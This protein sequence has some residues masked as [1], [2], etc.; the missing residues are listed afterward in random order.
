MK[1]NG[2]R[3]KVSNNVVIFTNN[4]VIFTNN[5]VIFTNND[6]IL[7]LPRSIRAERTALW[8]V[9]PVSL[10]IIRQRQVDASLFTSLTYVSFFSTRRTRRTQ[11]LT[12][13]IGV[14]KRC[15]RHFTELRAGPGPAP[16]RRDFSS[17]SHSV[18]CR[19]H[20]LINSYFIC[21]ALC[22]P[23]PLCFKI[24][25]KLGSFTYY[26]HAGKRDLLTDIV[27]DGNQSVVTRTGRK[28]I[29]P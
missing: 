16:T 25:A 23:C 4:V 14:F 5:V 19:R 27:R 7:T 12:L 2:C 24:N 28:K 21:I 10:P 17:R 6:V 20:L 3:R 1:D 11:R 22:P 15:L 8:P 18:Q 9:F 13:L 29:R 26:C